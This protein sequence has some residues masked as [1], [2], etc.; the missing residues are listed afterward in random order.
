MNM[1]STTAVVALL[2]T[3]HQLATAAEPDAPPSAP[4]AVPLP[5]KPPDARPPQSVAPSVAPAAVAN[6]AL[7]KMRQEG[8]D[9]VIKARREG[10]RPQL[11][12]R[13]AHAS[14]L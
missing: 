10:N 6:P 5:V 2:S 1:L 11:R 13:I 3:A 14:R 7:P 8:I 4:R 9:E 12:Q